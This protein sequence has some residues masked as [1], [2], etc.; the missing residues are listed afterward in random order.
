VISK[1]TAI[2]AILTEWTTNPTSP[3]PLLCRF[4]NVGGGYRGFTE[5]RRDEV[6]ILPT[7][8]ECFRTQQ[9]FVIN[10]GD[11]DTCDGTPS[12]DYIHVLDVADYLIYR[13]HRLLAGEPHDF[14]EM[15][16]IGRGQ[17]V[18]VLELLE[19]CERLGYPIPS[20]YGPVAPAA[21]CHGDCP[22]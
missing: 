13:T 12:R 4:F 22:G 15:V 5:R 8:W 9:P 19:I 18:T 6:H 11:Y 10:G 2:Q 16:H 1:E 7:L 21:R 20:T 3:I 17:P 14:S